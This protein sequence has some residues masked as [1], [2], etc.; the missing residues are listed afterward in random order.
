MY[1]YLTPSLEKGLLGSV[2]KAVVSFSSRE[3][4]FTV[5]TKGED[6]LLL[7]LPSIN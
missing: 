3:L 1:F 4:S 2:I 7:I 5:P 6:L